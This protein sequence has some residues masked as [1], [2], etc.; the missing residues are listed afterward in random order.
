M[1]AKSDIEATRKIHRKFDLEY[2]KRELVRLGYDLKLIPRQL[3]LL[4]SGKARFIT[5]DTGLPGR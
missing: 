2:V 1:G 5:I 3:F 4:A